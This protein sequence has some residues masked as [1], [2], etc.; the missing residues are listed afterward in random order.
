MSTMK[1]SVIV[2]AAYYVIIFGG[3]EVM[4][5]REAFSFPTIFKIHNLFLTLVSGGMLVLFIEQILSTVVSRGL[6]YSMCDSEGG[7]THKLVVLYYVSVCPGKDLESMTLTVCSSTTSANT[8][9]FSI[10]CT[11]S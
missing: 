4:R 9:S 10:L 7:W 6:Y 8:S 3:R 11:W 1:E 5:N 2:L